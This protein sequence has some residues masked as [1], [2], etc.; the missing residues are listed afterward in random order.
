MY[1]LPRSFVLSFL[2]VLGCCIGSFLN[3]CIHR[4]PS[5]A[6]LWDQLKALNSHGSGCPRCAAS[7]KWRD[8]IPLLGWLMLR[9]RC[10]NCHQSI[11]K[12]Y[13]LVELLT[14]ILFVFVYQAEMPTNFWNAI[15]TTWHPNTSIHA[16]KC[17]AHWYCC[18]TQ[19]FKCA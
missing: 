3:V 1:D 4:F 14:G 2:F 5:K 16:T 8:N 9:G 18:T 7:I 13:P 17:W 12:R 10:R 11:S 19:I 15:S 6:S